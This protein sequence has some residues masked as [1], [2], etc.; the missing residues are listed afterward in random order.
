MS[1]CEKNPGEAACADTVMAAVATHPG[2]PPAL[3]ALMALEGYLENGGSMRELF[4][5]DRVDL[6]ILYAYGCQRYRQGDYEGARQVLLALASIDP[7]AFRYWLALGLALQKIQRHDEALCCFARAATLR[8]S[9]PRSS[10]FAGVS[11]Q[12]LGDMAHA[13]EAFEAAV[14]GCGGQEAYG[15]LRQ[16]AELALQAVLATI[17]GEMQ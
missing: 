10:F 13:R 16:Q 4:G 8:L 1:Q 11:F 14:K 12:L 2:L 7:H 17:K 3:Q 9:D 5:I 15:H 6:E